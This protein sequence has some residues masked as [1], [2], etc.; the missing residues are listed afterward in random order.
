VDSSTGKVRVQLENLSPNLGRVQAVTA[1]AGK[2]ASQ[3]GAG[4]PLFPHMVRWTEVDWP[5]PGTP[6]RLMVRFAR[7]SLDTSLTATSSP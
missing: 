1:S 4:F 3:P 7:F 5:G 6:D 2:V